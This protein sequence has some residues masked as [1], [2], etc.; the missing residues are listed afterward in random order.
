MTTD[1]LADVVGAA[2]TGDCVG[3]GNSESTA[4]SLEVPKERPRLS[5]LATSENSSS[6]SHPILSRAPMPYG[7]IHGFPANSFAG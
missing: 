5:S 1:G 3:A 2:V 6:C 7:H 4:H